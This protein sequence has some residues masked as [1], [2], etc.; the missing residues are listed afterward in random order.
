M[1]FIRFA[2]LASIALVT[3]ACVVVAHPHPRPPPRILSA[4]E[5]VDGA[6]YFA[7]SHGLIVDYTSDVRL[8][9]HARWH[10]DLGGAGGR[11]R[12]LVTLDG[13]TGRVLRARLHDARG[14]FV[15]EPSPS[16]PP[17]RSPAPA[18]RDTTGAPPPEMAPPPPPGSAP[19]HPPAG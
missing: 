6:T 10:V 15:P 18:P 12:A 14:E 16:A 1:R 2:V 13:Y 9:R 19:P 3:S 7:R 5:A 4:Q 8:D 11:D 17:A